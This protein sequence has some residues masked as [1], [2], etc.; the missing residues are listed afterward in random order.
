MTRDITKFE[1]DNVQTSK[2]FSRFEIHRTFL[3]TRGG[4]QTSHLCDQQVY[5]LQL[6][7]VLFTLQSDVYT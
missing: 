3:L 4:I 5:K 2:V 6:E 1:F 7:P